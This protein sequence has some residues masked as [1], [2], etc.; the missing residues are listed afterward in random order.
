MIG[1]LNKYDQLFK[2][3]KLGKD[4][5]GRTK[6]AKSKQAEIEKLTRRFST[7][8]V[9][10][11]QDSRRALLAEINGELSYYLDICDL[12]AE[13]GM[14]EEAVLFVRQMYQLIYPVQEMASTRL[15]LIGRVA[16]YGNAEAL[17]DFIDNAGLTNAQLKWLVFNPRPLG[18]ETD[19][20]TYVLFGFKT[21][22]AQFVYQKLSS[23]F[24]DR[25]ELIKHVAHVVNYQLKPKDLS[26]NSAPEKTIE[27][28]SLD[29][30]VAMIDH[31]FGSDECWN[32]SQ[33]YAYHQRPESK[34]W[35][36]KA[37][38]NRDPRAIKQIA[39]ELFDAHDYGAAAALMFEQ[40]HQGTQAPLP[41]SRAAEAY[42]LAGDS[43]KAKRLSF[44]AFVL[45]VFNYDDNY[46]ETYG[47]YLADERADLISQRLLY[48]YSTGSLS[49]QSVLLGYSWLVLTKP[50]PVAASN[51]MKIRVLASSSNSRPRYLISLATTAHEMEATAAVVKEQYAVADRLLKRLLDFSPATPSVAEKTVVQLDLAGQTEMADEVI[52]QLAKTYH[53]LLER[54]PVS[55]T[56]CNNYA[57]VL[58]CAKRYPEAALRHAKTAVDRR[59]NNPGFIDTLAE[60]YYAGGKFDEAISG[61]QYRRGS[62]ASESLLRQATFEI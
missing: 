23:K 16:D 46:E 61:Y 2:E 52:E 60:S 59:P 50:D 18:G 11:N 27:P 37:A 38:A 58:A 57:W 45:P 28:F 31:S 33:I 1:Y 43:L 7:T 55:S 9:R 19:D 20:K 5:K 62:R 12:F 39:N 22:V 32:I 51:F 25:M 36:E 53:G 35:L 13:L 49:N 44:H 14:E 42:G 4:L 40:E 47:A 56:H 6:W 34:Q 8:L 17:W 54:F 21:V 26:S 24:D 15:D 10:N 30:E 48:R 29:A 3:L 41:L